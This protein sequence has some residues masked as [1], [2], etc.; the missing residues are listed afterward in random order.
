MH[1]VKLKSQTTYGVGKKKKKKD[2]NEGKEE[3]ADYK[4]PERGLWLM[5][6]NIS[7]KME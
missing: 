3:T 2:R 7:M 5:I 6:K 1:T 4:H